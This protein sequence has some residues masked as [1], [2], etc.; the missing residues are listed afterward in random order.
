MKHKK[1]WIQHLETINKNNDKMNFLV[2]NIVRWICKIFIVIILVYLLQRDL[3]FFFHFNIEFQFIAWI[4]TFLSG[5]LLLG[6]GLWL[7]IGFMDLMLYYLFGVRYKVEKKFRI[8]Y[9]ILSYLKESVQ[10][11]DFK[12]ISFIPWGDLTHFKIFINIR[13]ILLSIIFILIAFGIFN[14]SSLLSFNLYHGN[15]FPIFNEYIQATNWN[16]G[17][18]NIRIQFLYIIVLALIIGPPMIEVYQLFL[19]NNFGINYLYQPAKG[20]I[21]KFIERIRKRRTENIMTRLRYD[22]DKN[23]RTGY[24]FWQARCLVVLKFIILI[25]ILYLIYPLH[26]I[27]G[28]WFEEVV[29]FF[30]LNE[31]YSF[32]FP[33]SEFFIKIAKYL[34]ITL[35]GY[36]GLYIIYYLYQYFF[37][38][39]IFISDTQKIYYRH[40]KWFINQLY[41]IEP[42]DIRLIS[43]QQNWFQ[44]LVMSGDIILVRISGDT[45]HIKGISRAASFIHL[46]DNLTD[47]SRK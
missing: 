19:M 18:L 31:I 29:S 23:I 35:L 41:I 20:V 2:I 46:Y 11:L 44:R 13:V 30:K 9:K 15:A 14:S 27:V 38:E 34:F 10:S 39:L 21:P 16:W 3:S 37:S 8:W 12:N 25:G 26:V 45:I 36:F 7:G 40:R 43:L 6:I 4:L 22:L 5:I 1:Y 33:G 28:G 17:E 24:C 47:K 42:D 32:E